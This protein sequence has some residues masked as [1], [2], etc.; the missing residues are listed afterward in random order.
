MENA[1]ERM[2]SLIDDLLTFARVTT[3]GQ[4][5]APVDLNVIAA[6]VVGD[7]EARLQETG[8]RIEVGPLPTLEADGTQ[9]RQLLQNLLGNA[10]KFHKPD[11]PPVV[12]VY[13]RAPE[14]SGPLS[15]GGHYLPERWRIMVQDNGIGFDEKYRNHVFGLFQR[16]HDRS[17]YEGSGIGLAVCRRIVERHGG[18]IDVTS[19]AGQGATF[20]VALPLRQAQPEYKEVGADGS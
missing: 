17:R 5:P 15:N 8:G 13:A 9:M 11:V 7:L 18:S 2:Q 6:Q 12:K 3:R 10:L 4:P 14:L 16:L 1:A 19:Q 20:T